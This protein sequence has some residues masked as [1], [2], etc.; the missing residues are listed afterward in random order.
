MPDSEV[1]QTELYK[2]NENRNLPALDKDGHSIC[3]ENCL[4]G[5]TGANLATY[6]AIA[7]SMNATLS[8]EPEC[9]G[10][11]NEDKLVNETDVTNWS[12]FS[13]SKD[14]DGGSSSWYD[15]DHD[16]QTDDTDLNQFILPNLG[17]NCLKTNNGKGNNNGNKNGK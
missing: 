5:L 13:Q 4:T 15:F 10:D 2:I 9:P 16:G 1:V 11:G 17:N 12:I 3:G 8:S 14:L 7:A 6:N